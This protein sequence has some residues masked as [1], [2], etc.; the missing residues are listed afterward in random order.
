MYFRPELIGDKNV[1]YSIYT[2]DATEGLAGDLYEG[3]GLLSWGLSQPL[4]LAKVVSGFIKPSLSGTVLEVRMKL[5]QVCQSSQQDF[6]TS[7]QSF[8][9]ISRTLPATFDY[10]N[11]NEFMKHATI[12]GTNQANVPTKPAIRG[13]SSG[14]INTLQRAREL[15]ARQTPQGMSAQLKTARQQQHSQQRHARLIAQQAAAKQSSS[16]IPPSQPQQQ[17]RADSQEGDGP[18]PEP[19]SPQLVTPSS[20]PQMKIFAPPPQGVARSNSLPTT[21]GSESG[22]ALPPLAKFST[23]GGTD[24]IDD[25]G[26]RGRKRKA[27]EMT[28]SVIDYGHIPVFSPSKAVNAAKNSIGAVQ[29][30]FKSKSPT[31]SGASS[32]ANMHADYGSKGKDPPN[33]AISSK[34]V[35]RA[36]PKK[37]AVS[38]TGVLSGPNLSGLQRSDAELLK[39]LE[40]GQPIKFCYNCGNIQTK[41]NW[42]QLTVNGEKHSLCNA[43][44]VYWKTRNKMRPEKLWGRNRQE[45]LRL[46]F[47]ARSGPV[48][49]DLT[50]QQPLVSS[51]DSAQYDH[52]VVAQT[53]PAKKHDHQGAQQRIRETRSSPA[54]ARMQRLTNGPRLIPEPQ[55]GATNKTRSGTPPRETLHELQVNTPQPPPSPS[56]A[57]GNGFEDL[58]ALLQT[59]KKSFTAKV[60][61]SPSP[62][63]SMFTMLDDVQKEGPDSPSRQKLDK[64]LEDLGMTNGSGNLNFDFNAIANFPLSPTA[65]GNLDSIASFMSSPPGMEFFTS[66]GLEHDNST[67]ED[68]EQPMSARKA[69]W[70]S[71]V[72]PQKS[73]TGGGGQDADGEESL[74]TPKKRNTRSQ[75]GSVS[76]SLRSAG[77]AYGEQMFGGALR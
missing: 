28:S 10:S 13:S 54:Q 12:G 67:P 34:G 50:S 27:N 19:A 56:P 69:D 64:F 75:P 26:V 36:Q 11:W 7:M 47:P 41:G 62:W 48:Q 46:D 22:L 16:N 43:C 37:E 9:R 51:S 74:F 15:A 70:R 59:P 42:R 49:Q 31:D 3:Q 25:S 2:L 5:S 76:R 18:L 1:D 17:R 6:I 8:E 35:A 72:T 58:V 24:P 14:Q 68:Q 33:S 45:S 4:R 40:D 53:S 65:Q 30:L 55:S 20:P 23:I 32:P 63:R 71:K 52:S 21:N 29:L 77:A 61:S 38:D 73:G 66:S 39:A 60:M 57:S 44:G